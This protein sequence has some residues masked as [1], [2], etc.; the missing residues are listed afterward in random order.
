MDKVIGTKEN[1]PSM[2]DGHIAFSDGEPM[3]LSLQVI[4][5]YKYK[6]SYN[7]ISSLTFSYLCRQL[8]QKI[9]QNIYGVKRGRDHNPKAVDVSTSYVR[10]NYM[11]W[12]PGC[13][14]RASQELY[15]CV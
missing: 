10:Y 3:L 11:S 6:L 14:D 7:V 12:A 4:L 13:S 8:Y 15:L 1:Q 5:L 2:L 9:Y